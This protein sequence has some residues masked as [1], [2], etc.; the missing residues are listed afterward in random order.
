[1]WKRPERLNPFCEFPES[2]GAQKL[3]PRGA[4]LEGQGAFAKILPSKTK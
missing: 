3:A 1:M 4:G 2:E